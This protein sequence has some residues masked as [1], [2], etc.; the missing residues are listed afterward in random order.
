MAAARFDRFRAEVLEI[1]GLK[2]PA[3]R[4]KVGQVLAELR[5]AGARTTADLAPVTVARWIAAHPGRS[6]ATWR[7]LLGT[8][9]AVANLAVAA[10]QL[11]PGR[12]P[13][14]PRSRWVPAAPDRAGPRRHHSA[15]ELAR[16]LALLDAEAAA[17]DWGRHRLRALVYLVAYTGMR[18]LEA[19]GLERGDVALD[20]RMIRLRANRWRPL[21]TPQSG[22]PV[23]LADRPAAVL[24]DWLPRCGPSGLVFPN[25]TRPTPW[26]AGRP[27]AKP[28]DQ[29]RAAGE[30]ASVP[31]LTFL[32]LR[33]SWA[34][35]AETLWGLS[36]PQ[37]ARVLRH[38]TERTSIDHYRHADEANLRALAGR[39]TFEEPTRARA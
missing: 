36:G 23:P 5:A 15:A 35:H 31:G 26:F 34:T 6:P 37:I 4:L 33:H 8:L 13:A 16:V 21:K 9:R 3:T 1:Y 22:Q 10:G 20:G 11:P 17:G 30:R 7:R 19:L 38:T 27:G 29:V 2:A 28:L 12:N 24:A 14:V 39:I 25:R 32:S 18:R